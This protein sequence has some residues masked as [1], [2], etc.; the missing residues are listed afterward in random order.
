MLLKLGRLF[1]R[2]ALVSV[3][4]NEVRVGELTKH[5]G[6]SMVH[7]FSSSEEGRVRWVPMAWHAQLGGAYKLP[8]EEPYLPCY[9]AYQV[10]GTE[11]SLS[12]AR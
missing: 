7:E 1:G 3:T 6:G 11:I 5:D 2:V 9:A 4:I 10:F 12:S 8:Q